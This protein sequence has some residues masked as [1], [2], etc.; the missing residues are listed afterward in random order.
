[1]SE[2]GQLLQGVQLKNVGLSLA[3]DG[4]TVDSV[5]GDVDFTD[6]GIEG[7]AGFQL[8]RKAVK[9]IFNGSKASL[10]LIAFNTA[11]STAS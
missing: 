7:P 2:A 5:F 6:G 11:L 1:M 9:A 10:T 4:K 8:S 3:I